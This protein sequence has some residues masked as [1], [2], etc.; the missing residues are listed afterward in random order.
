MS[1]ELENLRSEN[2]LLKKQININQSFISDMF[3]DLIPV[4]SE[5]KNSTG[6][7]KIF[8][9]VKLAV[10][11]VALIFKHFDTKPREIDW[12]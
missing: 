2:I 9:I 6:F 8:K 7:F 10:Y 4:A 1:K 5:I 3:N 12:Y 11:L